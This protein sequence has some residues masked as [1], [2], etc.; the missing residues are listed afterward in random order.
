MCA[1]PDAAVLTAEAST[2]RACR[3]IRQPDAGPRSCQSVSPEVHHL[4]VEKPPCALWHLP[5]V[6]IRSCVRS[7]PSLAQTRPLRHI[8]N[9][10]WHSQTRL[11]TRRAS[12]IPGGAPRSVILV[13]QVCRPVRRDTRR[14]G[15]NTA[16]RCA[17]QWGETAGSTWAQ[18]AG[19][20]ANPVTVVNRGNG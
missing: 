13:A 17:L 11:V 8:V 19:A 9:N 10:R 18:A 14:R 15:A 12:G 3:R 6:P 16:T 5:V 2:A 7:D 4:C 1:P 20:S